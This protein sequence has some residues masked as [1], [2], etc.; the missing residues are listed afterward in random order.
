MISVY[1]PWGT[2]TTVLVL[3]NGFNNIV[4]IKM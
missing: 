4:D 3:A 1:G 2:E